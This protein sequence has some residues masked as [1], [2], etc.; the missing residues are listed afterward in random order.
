MMECL[1]ESSLRVL[2]AGLADCFEQMRSSMMFF[3]WLHV[4]YR[5]DRE[6]RRLSHLPGCHLMAMNWTLAGKEAKET[7]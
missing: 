4:T 3:W 7:N 1:N 6:V 2:G 5:I